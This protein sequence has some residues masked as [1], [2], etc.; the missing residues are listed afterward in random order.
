MEKKFP[1]FKLLTLLIWLVLGMG[2]AFGM[3]SWL[4]HKSATDPAY[5]SKAKCYQ[6]SSAAELAWF[7]DFVNKQGSGSTSCAKL[8]SDLDLSG[9]FWIPISVGGTKHKVN[10]DGNGHVIRNLYISAAEILALPDKDCATDENC[11]W[12]KYPLKNT[13]EKA[14]N[15]GLIGASTGHVQRVILEN[16]Q[17]YAFGKNYQSTGATANNNNIVNSP[18]S[19][20]TV[21]GWQSGN[22]TIEDCYVTGEMI[23]EGD[24]QAVGG[25]VGNN[26]G[27]T[28]KNCYSAV[29]IHA[30]GLAYVGGIAGYTKSF[31]NG[32]V[33]IESCV[34]D[35]E[36]L[37]SEGS[38]IVKI[39]GKETEFHS[40]VG[41]IVGNHY[42]GS[43]T[44]SN[45]Y[46]DEEKFGNGV[47]EDMTSV[48]GGE[49][50]GTPE[51]V[52]LLDTDPIVC[53]LND[54][55]IKDG[56][57]TKNSPWSVGETGLSLNDYGSDCCAVV[58]DANGGSFDDGLTVEKHIPAGD[59]V[60]GDG[61]TPQ[62]G[63]DETYAGGYVFVGWSV[64]KN[65]V[66]QDETIT[67]SPAIKK[68]YAV[69]KPV[70]TV[71][72]NANNGTFGDVTV[73]E[74]YFNKGEKIGVPNDFPKPQKD[75]FYLKGWNTDADAQNA[76]VDENGF[77]DLPNANEH[78]MTLYAIWT[79]TPTHMVTFYANGHGTTVSGYVEFTVGD[80]ETIESLMGEDFDFGSV[81]GYTL[82]KEHW[83][84]DAECTEEFDLTTPITSDVRLYANWTLNEYTITFDSRCNGCTSPSSGTYSVENRKFK[85]NGTYSDPTYTNPEWNASHRFIG[86]SLS[87]SVNNI[88][89]EIPEG[90]AE[91]LILYA[92]WDVDVFTI[93]YNAGAYGKGNGDIIPVVQTEF[94]ESHNIYG[95]LFARDGYTQ[96]GWSTSDGSET[97][98]YE[99]NQSV[100]NVSLNLYPHWTLRESTIAVKAIS[101]E[102]TYD[103]QRHYAECSV[104]GLPEG[105]TFTPSQ[106]TDYQTNV[107]NKVVSCSPKIKDVNNNDVTNTFTIVYTKGTISVKAAET[108]IGAVTI[109]TDQ[110]GKRAVIDGEYTGSDAIDIPTPIEVDNIVINRTFTRNT[111][112]TIVLPFTLPDGT[113]L[114]G[115]KF[116]YLKNVVQHP[117][118]YAWKATMKWIG[119]GA[120]P[121]ANTP[122]LV[123]CT[124]ENC[125]SLEF[126]LNGKA[127]FKTDELDWVR[128]EETDKWYFVGTYVYKTW[129]SKD[130]QKELADGL[131]YGIAGKSEGD[132][133]KGTFAKATSSAN[134]VYPM[135]AYMR[136]RDTSVKLER[137]TQPQTVRARGASY[138]LNNI[139][140]EII[141]VE[142]VDDEKTTAIG[143]M[144]TVTGEIKIDRWFD[145]KGRH[146]KN[147]NRAAKGAYYG[148]KVIHE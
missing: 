3:E 81:D 50:T 118:R 78:N 40:Q 2:T 133:P 6:I 32:V 132:V 89:S 86:W 68:V 123:V 33:T 146:V 31:E 93:T 53:Y 100:S 121:S 119:D 80:N 122:Y 115:A 126:G 49:T 106:S 94:G 44:F 113:N 138:G 91:D 11:P 69:W 74:L 56:V 67:A 10:F 82:N 1:I 41:A 70:Y 62:R 103:G 71:K 77:D 131:V 5:D 128:A 137:V 90:I 109:I 61:L 39:N 37:S 59:V 60:N 125:S 18:L 4:A 135:R 98:D 16:V 143:R 148:K 120:L 14:Q 111:P 64:D 7:A 107:G 55:E 27:G 110:N 124:K 8:I 97:I 99:F 130:E 108:Q 52:E 147:V 42:N 65:A 22:S 112:A 92:V 101:A 13:S 114:N 38:G 51:G 145:L 105:F 85:N 73:K 76:L 36:S 17:V 58:F 142:F 136:K 127:T 117:T 26:G 29:N 129:E 35:G 15:L 54:G 66:V 46:Y 144:N 45:V 48:Y 141:E 9:Y 28:I 96:D 140:S 43:T 102:F 47:G 57:C 75:G 25:I 12:N 30:N 23:T 20:G 87:S 134:E 84:V 24:G 139:G 79:E 116:Y 72:F 95:V 88:V 19:I 34:Y 83:C 104:E 63:A 21:V